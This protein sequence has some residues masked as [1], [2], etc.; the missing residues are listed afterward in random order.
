MSLFDSE[1]A[2]I[3][4]NWVPLTMDASVEPRWGFLGETNANVISSTDFGFV[5]KKN[6]NHK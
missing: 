2:Y 4:G 5:Y 6:K 1:F 3:F